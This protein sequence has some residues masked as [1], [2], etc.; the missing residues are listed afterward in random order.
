MHEPV[1]HGDT[2]SHSARQLPMSQSA[3]ATHSPLVV[4]ASPIAIAPTGRHS[5]ALG[6]PPRSLASAPHV[7]PT[8]QEPVVSA[9]HVGAHTPHALDGAAG[10]QRSSAPHSHVALQNARHVVAASP[11][12]LQIAALTH[13]SSP[14]M[15]PAVQGEPVG[16][17]GPG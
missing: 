2:P 17:Y 13:T 3:S 16:R 8:E 6:P 5:I 15:T 7:A 12:G 10:V 11:M 9:A 14:G 1:V 4:H